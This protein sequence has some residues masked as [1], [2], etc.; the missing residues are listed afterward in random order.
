[1]KY[2]ASILA[3]ILCSS[4]FLRK[5]QIDQ[6]EGTLLLK[7]THSIRYVLDLEIDGK[8]VPI[9]YTGGNRFLLVEGLKPGAHH[10]NLHSITYVFGPE[11]ERFELKAGEKVSFTVQ[12]RK[13]RTALPKRKEQVSIRAYR[14]QLAKAERKD[15]PS[16]GSV[17]ARFL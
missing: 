3:L 17:R 2:G 14:K 7:F 1:M 4:C 11:F 5:T 6:P 16:A 12:S 9:D 10:F 13:Y 8:P 15:P